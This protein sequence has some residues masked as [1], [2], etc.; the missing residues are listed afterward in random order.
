MSKFNRSL[1]QYRRRQ[2]VEAVAMLNKVVRQADNE[3]DIEEALTLK[4]AY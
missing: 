4:F 3:M 1:R 2:N